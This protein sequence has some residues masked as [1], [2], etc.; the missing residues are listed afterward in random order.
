MSILPFIMAYARS[1]Q[2]CK[3]TTTN[4]SVSTVKDMATLPSCLHVVT[5]IRKSVRTEPLHDISELHKI[6]R[7]NYFWDLKL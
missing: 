3:M 1:K 4:T 2:F 6:H 7:L 5:Q